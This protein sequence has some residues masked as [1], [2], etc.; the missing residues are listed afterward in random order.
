[1]WT[2]PES[3][4][5]YRRLPV[6]D[7]PAGCLAFQYGVEGRSGRAVPMTACRAPDAIWTIPGD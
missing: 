2:T 1:M 4:A 7:L 3:R 5:A 6:H